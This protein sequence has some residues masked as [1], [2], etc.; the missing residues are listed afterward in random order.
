MTAER[1]SRSSER[2]AQPLLR[3]LALTLSLSTAVASVFMLTN[4]AP[5]DYA[6]R[7]ERAAQAASGAADASARDLAQARRKT[8]AAT[9]TR[10]ADARAPLQLAY[11]E[12]AA[13]GRLGPEGNAQIL[14]SYA[15]EPL[16]PGATLWR[17][18]FIF[19]NWSTTSVEVRRAALRELDATFARLGWDL[20]AA[21]P[22]ITDPGGRMIA[23][24]SISRL[25]ARENRR[26]A[27][28]S[29]PV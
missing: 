19:D 28:S 26:N 20:E 25:R 3:R 6:G 23:L 4:L 7:R 5:W 21:A 18:T 11:L 2:R 8:V 17:L 22:T 24:V 9:V 16:G 1:T 29:D 12:R 15:L 27:G 14:R 13:S 10:P